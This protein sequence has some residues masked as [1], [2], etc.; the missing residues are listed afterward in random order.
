MLWHLEKLQIPKDKL[1]AYF[2]EPNASLP[3]L[4]HITPF[5]DDKDVA[6]AAVSRKGTLLHEF[7]DR[8]KNDKDVVLIAIAQDPKAIASASKS[9]RGD[10][11]VAIACLYP[12]ANS[13]MNNEY[14]SYFSEEIKNNYG[15]VAST[16]C[17]VRFASEAI[18][19]DKPL[20]TDL[21]KDNY[22]QFQY[23]GESLKNDVEFCRMA[24]AQEATNFKYI[25]AESPL[26]SDKAF[27]IKV[28]SRNPDCLEYMPK[29]KDNTEVV[30]H[31]VRTENKMIE[32][33]LTFGFR[34][35]SVINHSSERLQ[36]VVG[37]NDAEKSLNSLVL[38][39]KL[40]NTL[41]PKK[42]LKLTM[43]I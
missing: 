5:K 29:F 31:A 41:A 43:K 40:N 32:D 4:S 34:D 7:S 9:L 12:R 10:I 18:R 1:L 27:C 21:V 22:R 11:D 8:I 35:Q 6:I 42:S 23:A 16:M 28:L 2:G 14:L 13:H 3:N 25:P 15:L 33:K 38:L 19:G 36:K 30:L 20:M 17:N 24:V 37:D 39:D 26:K